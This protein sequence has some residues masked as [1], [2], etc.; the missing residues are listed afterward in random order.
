M[1]IRE[2][3]LKIHSRCDL[4][5]DHCYVYEHADQSWHG[6]PPVISEEALGQAARRLA[7]YAT[8]HELTSVTV[9]LHGGEPLLVGPARLRHICAELARTLTPVTVLDLRIHTNGVRLDRAHLDVLKEFNVRVG[10][11]L[12]GDRAA[13]DR[14]RRDRRG[15]SSY[16]RVLQ[17]LELLRDPEYQHLYQ[18][19]LCTVDVANDP[20]AVHDALTALTPP[21]LDYLL[22]HATWQAPPP[23]RTETATPYADWLLAVFD[24]WEEQGRPMPVRVFS[25]VLSTLRG[26]PSLTE[27]MGLAPTEL[28]VVETD[29]TFEQADSLKTAFDG[30]PATGYDVFRHGFAEFARHPGVLARQSGIAGVSET[31]RRCPVVESCGG[32]LYAHRYSTERGFDN[33]S[34]YCADLRSF[35]EGVA[36]RITERTLAPAVTG[37][38][39]LEL[40]QLEL[41]HALLA[42]LNT[43]LVGSLDWDTLWRLL[44]R[45]DSDMTTA[46]HLDTV[47]THPYLR[48]ALL[49][50]W[51][52]PLDLPRLMAAGVAAAVRARAEAT[53]AW[54]HTDVSVHLPTLG[55]VGLSRPGRVEFRVSADGFRVR[56]MSS[57][58]DDGED[59]EET[60]EWRPLRSLNLPS[61]PPLLL[62]DADPYRD[63]YPSPVTPPLRPSDANVFRE[64]LRTAY[65][66]LDERVPH[67]R[68]DNNAPA[69]TTIT[70]LG[71]GAG[72]QLGSGGMRALGV[73]VDFAPEDFVRELPR[74]GRRARLT[75]LRQV[76]DLNVPGNRAGQLLDLVS[77][78]MGRAVPFS[79]RAAE[80]WRRARC[81]LDELAALPDSDLTETGAYLADE[82]RTEWTALHD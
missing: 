26:G 18:G 52:G 62:D 72:L 48:P 32:G 51:R 10:L 1:P 65:A 71:A 23:G 47:L 8:E 2:V 7:E 19:L 54:D 68:Q 56:G 6:R 76:A 14:H 11:S 27:S 42:D 22:P 66:L 24:R 15:R 81:A 64:R 4:A 20:V 46:P 70:P 41:D 38:G 25:S 3:V 17:G 80:A 74:L 75:A 37:A 50:S 45:L 43:R 36:E 12:D 29:G 28:A 16:E 79:S 34:V 13:N 21:R 49:R 60:T 59:V 57:G 78:T 40:A 55:T 63:C 9:I 73:A 31:C 33:P 82:L 53:L 69:T 39:E 5:C 61:G 67:W 30:A 44:V 35:I 77:D 58:R